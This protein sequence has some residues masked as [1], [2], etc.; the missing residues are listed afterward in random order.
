[1]DQSGNWK[2]SPVGER[3]KALLSF[4]FTLFLNPTYK[5]AILDLPTKLDPRADT[6]NAREII[7]ESL[8]YPLLSKEAGHQLSSEFLDLDRSQA[9][10]SKFDAF[11]FCIKGDAQFSDGS[12]IKVEDLE[13]SLRDFHHNAWSL[14]KIEETIVQNECL[15]VKLSHSDS[16]YFEK[17]TD[18]SSTVIKRGTENEALPVGLGPYKP[19]KFEGGRLLATANGHRVTGDFKNLEFIGVRSVPK[20]S[21][22]D[23]Q[24]WNSIY[25]VPLPE[26]VKANYIPFQRL[27]HKSYV[28]LAPMKEKSVR[29]QFAQCLHKTSF[30][31]ALGM[32]LQPRL[33]YIPEGILGSRIELQKRKLSSECKFEA[34]KETVTLALLN[35]EVADSVRNYFEKRASELPVKVRVEAVS[36]PV[37]FSHWEKRGPGMIVGGFSNR[38][39]NPEKFFQ[40][41]LPPEVP[42]SH[43]IPG[44][45]Q[46]LIKFSKERNSGERLQLIERAH[47]LLLE[48]GYIVPLGQLVHTFYYPG[49]IYNIQWKTLS[50]VQPP[51]DRLRLDALSYFYTRLLAKL[52]P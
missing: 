1:M 8:Y 39:S 14:R 3:M 45:E 46:L 26:R 41:F 32:S 25:N 11:R 38:I 30:I 7:Y 2:N 12:F 43:E 36:H 48:S 40:P 10:S 17:L 9:L 18:L 31:E 28:L 16:D 21:Q 4:L 6:A 15:I 29:K 13:F 50:S 34:P 22:E 20:N 47:A 33:G 19:T 49:Y 44:L 42:K 51:I 35:S 37:F 5:V 24:D 52:S 27:L 23:I